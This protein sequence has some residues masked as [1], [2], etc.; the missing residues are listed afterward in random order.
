MGRLDETR[1]IKTVDI[2]NHFIS[3]QKQVVLF[4]LFSIGIFLFSFLFFSLFFSLPDS[5][6]TIVSLLYVIS[7]DKMAGNIASP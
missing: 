1:C 3:C 6:Y 4:F 5:L 2:D 7:F